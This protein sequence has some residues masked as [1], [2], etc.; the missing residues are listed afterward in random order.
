MSVLAM[1]SGAVY[2]QYGGERTGSGEGYSTQPQSTVA[3]CGYLCDHASNANATCGSFLIQARG[4]DSNYPVQLQVGFHNSLILQ[5][6]QD[7]FILPFKFTS[8]RTAIY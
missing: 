4:Q 7:V 3:G 5:S 6:L 2:L 1:S 8:F